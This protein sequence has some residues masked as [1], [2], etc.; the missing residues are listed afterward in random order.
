MRTVI[1]FSIL[2]ISPYLSNG[3]DIKDMSVS[4]SGGLLNSPHFKQAKAKG[5][6]DFEFSYHL[7]KK[8]VLSVEY[9]KGRH[10]Y[11]DQILSNNPTSF[12]HMDGN[13]SDVIY[14]TFSVLYKYNV[15]D[16]D[17]INLAPSVG[18]GMVNLIN[19]Y[20]Y[21]DGNFNNFRRLFSTD[22]AFPVNLDIFYKLTKNWQ[23]GLSAGFFIEP[24]YPILALHVGPKISYVIK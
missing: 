24:D 9:I 6:Y 21:S 18:I 10:T 7:Q 3:Q 20:P 23:A 8:H 13:N 5:F 4:I 1:L 2:L 17:R 16:T 19:I 14:H 22:L 15:I 11:Y 12:T